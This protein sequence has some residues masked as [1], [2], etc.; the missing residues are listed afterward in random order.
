M[1]GLLTAKMHDCK[2]KVKP[3]TD[4]EKMAWACRDQLTDERN[5]IVCFH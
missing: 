4:R 3:V 2:E 5:V 1:H